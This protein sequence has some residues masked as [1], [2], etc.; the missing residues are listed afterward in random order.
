[1]IHVAT[2]VNTSIWA[3]IGKSGYNNVPCVSCTC[4]LIVVVRPMPFG[5]MCSLVHPQVSTTFIIYTRWTPVFC[6]LY[7]VMPIRNPPADYAPGHV[8][9]HF[10]LSYWLHAFYPAEQQKHTVY[11]QKSFETTVGSKFIQGYATDHLPLF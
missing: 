7:S 2:Y 4:V 5:E 1:M 9:R 8:L 11:W 3:A 10:P 6:D